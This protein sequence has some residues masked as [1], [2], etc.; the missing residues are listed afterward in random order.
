MYLRIVLSYLMSVVL[1][2][3]LA[4]TSSSKSNSVTQFFRPF[5]LVIDRYGSFHLTD[6]DILILTDADTDTNKRKQIHR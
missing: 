5:F 6:T 4:A 3:F 2:V 1:D